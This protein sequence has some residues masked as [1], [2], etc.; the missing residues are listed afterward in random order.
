MFSQSN[1]ERKTLFLRLPNRKHIERCWNHIVSSAL[2]ASLNIPHSSGLVQMLQIHVE[3]FEMVGMQ[4]SRTLFSKLLHSRWA[5]IHPSLEKKGY[6][7]NRSRT[8]PAEASATWEPRSKI[9]NWK[10]T[11]VYDWW[12]WNI[13][14]DPGSRLNGLPISQIWSSPQGTIL[15]LGSM[16]STPSTRN[17]GDVPFFPKSLTIH[18]RT[19]DDWGCYSRACYPLVN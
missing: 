9:R 13:L 16:A 17:T 7:T 11:L 18:T 14:H 19:C 3:N 1:W 5:S 12:Q 8:F 15:N 4:C 2:K 6:V 10:L